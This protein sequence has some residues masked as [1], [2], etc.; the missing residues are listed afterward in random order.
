M[1][2]VDERT[3]EALVDG[4]LGESERAAVLR[5]LDET[6][7]GWRRLALAFLADQAM[8]ETMSTLAAPSRAEIEPASRRELL[9]MPRPA[10][11]QPLGLA[12]RNGLRRWGLGLAAC[13]AC[14]VLAFFLGGWTIGSPTTIVD[15]TPPSKTSDPSIASKLPTDSAA[16][17]VSP[18]QQVASAMPNL[19][20]ST[21]KELERRGFVLQERPRVV[22]L[23][24]D[25]RVIQ[26]LVNEIEL[27]YVGQHSAL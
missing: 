5:Q 9:S 17:P 12:G 26:V 22:S 13:A 15:A 23:R 18:V 14:A 11:S 2:A 1:N 21:R 24:Q 10:G 27:R 16:P 7:D 19:S 6:A 4:E 8:R 3:L 20:P 25:G